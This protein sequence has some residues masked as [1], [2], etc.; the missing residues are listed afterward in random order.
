R[1][2]RDAG[3]REPEAR[4]YP[5]VAGRLVGITPHMLH[6]LP[7]TRATYCTANPYFGGENMR[8]YGAA[9][10][11]RLEREHPARV[12]LH[13]AKLFLPDRSAADELTTGT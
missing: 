11:I 6:P 8:T 10:T 13:S 5:G 3:Q 4:R 1:P 2:E 7:G 12:L 9:E